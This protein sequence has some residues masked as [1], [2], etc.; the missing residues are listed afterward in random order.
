MAAARGKGRVRIRHRRGDPILP[1]VEKE[2]GFVRH[3]RT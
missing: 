2:R 3:E 1:F